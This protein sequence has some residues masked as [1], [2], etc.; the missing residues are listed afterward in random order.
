MA[1]IIV[2]FPEVAKAGDP[3][4]PVVFPLEAHVQA[5]ELIIW[6]VY[7]RNSGLYSVR[8]SFP[9]GSGFFGAGVDSKEEDQ[10]FHAYDS[11]VNSDYYGDCMIVTGN[12]RTGKSTDKY[13][14]IGQDKIG[15]DVADW[16][17]DPKIITDGP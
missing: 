11:A 5:Q 10:I 15:K 13:S 6:E 2:V 14:V 1:R 9:A 4:K 17:L 16:T 12:P 7:S 8:L 3:G